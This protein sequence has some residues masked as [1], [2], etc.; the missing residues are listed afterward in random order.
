MSS[1]HISVDSSPNSSPHKG[2]KE[3]F[4]KSPALTLPFHPSSTSTLLVSECLCVGATGVVFAAHFG[5]L[6]LVIKAILPGHP[7]QSDLRH[8]ARLY[9]VLASLQGSVLPRM[10][11]LFEGEGW[12]MLI[13]EHCGDKVTDIS[14]L[15]LSQREMLWQHAC[16][17]HA[18]GVRHADLELRNFVASASGDVRIHSLNLG[19]SVREAHVR[20]SPSFNCYWSLFELFS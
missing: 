19:I 10:L 4:S 5:S 8:E 7:G 6:A 16:E 14:E 3:Y 17:I 20:S 13:A 2:L 18:K 9:N 11:G 1:S 12:L 15:S